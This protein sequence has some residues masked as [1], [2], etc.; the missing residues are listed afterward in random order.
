VVAVLDDM[1]IDDPGGILQFRSVF[2]G[3]LR[4]EHSSPRRRS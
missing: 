1:A 3:R 2:S 4:S